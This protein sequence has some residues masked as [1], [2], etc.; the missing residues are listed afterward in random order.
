MMSRQPPDL[1]PVLSSGSPSPQGT[2]SRHSRAQG[3]DAGPATAATPL[4]STEGRA[5]TRPPTLTLSVQNG[6]EAPRASGRSRTC[7]ATWSRHPAAGRHGPEGERQEAAIR[8]GAECRG[9]G[10]MWAEPG[11]WAGPGR[12][13]GCRAPLPAPA[14]SAGGIIAHTAMENKRAVLSELSSLISTLLLYV[15]KQG[16]K[17]ILSPLPRDSTPKLAEL[18]R[19]PV[20]CRSA[21]LRPPRGLTLG[22]VLLR[23]LLLSGPRAPSSSAQNNGEQLCVNPVSQFPPKGP[24]KEAKGPSPGRFENCGVTEDRDVRSAPEA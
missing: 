24:P 19:R 6:R 16:R 13:E 2:A 18:Q 22:S 5:G 4:R 17:P 20:S 21:L 3:C 1:R 10:G 9:R 11:L 8:G 15:P 12:A 23:P 7:P 14:C